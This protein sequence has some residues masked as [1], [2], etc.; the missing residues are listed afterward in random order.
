[1]SGGQGVGAQARAAG[2]R[3]A[4][5]SDHGLGPSATPWKQFLLH[6]DLF[7]PRQP[8]LHRHEGQKAEG[9][10]QLLKVKSGR[11]LGPPAVDARPLEA[12]P[13]YR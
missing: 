3:E 4:A 2:S 12:W 10:N 1:M 11:V 8:D 7:L 9:G 5:G 13:P 6:E